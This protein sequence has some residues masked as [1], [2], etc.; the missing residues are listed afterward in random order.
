M[1]NISIESTSLIEFKNASKAYGDKII[2]KGFD[3][4]F[5]PGTLTVLKGQNGTGKST[6]LKIC[7]NR[8]KLDDGDIMIK[9]G[10]KCRYMP[11][12]VDLPYADMPLGFIKWM[13]S[14]MK[15][16]LDLLFLSELDIDMGKEVSKLSKGNKQK[17]LLY[18]SLVGKPDIVCLDEPFT[19]L[20]Q[21]SIKIV[22]KRIHQLVSLGT[23]VLI[24]TH[25]LKSFKQHPFEVID[26]DDALHI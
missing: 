7:M 16:D 6:L 15:V 23:C 22:T 11:D 2:L 26:F 3:K 24:S 4:C 20:D 14:V 25:D 18:L 1:M 12:Y 21:K 8:V 19:A 10:I 13:L 9:K 5:H 17:L